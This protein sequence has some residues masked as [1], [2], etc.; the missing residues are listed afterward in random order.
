MTAFELDDTQ[1]LPVLRLHTPSSSGPDGLSDWLEFNRRRA[2]LDALRR[3]NVGPNI[4]RLCAQ[5]QDG[6]HFSIDG[7]TLTALP[8]GLLVS[9]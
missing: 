1:P 3:G 4:V 9:E 7:R 8:R 5:R 6:Y 2:E